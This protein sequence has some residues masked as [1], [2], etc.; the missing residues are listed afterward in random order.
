MSYARLGPDSD[1]FVIA[2]AQEFVCFCEMALAPGFKSRLSLIEHLWE[3]QTKGDLV[4]DSTFERLW[5]EVKGVGMA[6]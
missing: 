5:E 6:E 4:P 1:V 2:T 3:H